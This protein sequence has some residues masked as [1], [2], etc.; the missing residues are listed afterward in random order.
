MRKRF[1]W[2]S[3][4]QDTDFVNCTFGDEGSCQ[5]PKHRP[6]RSDSVE[7]EPEDEGF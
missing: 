2:F 3:R 1:Y 6:H 4:C 7:L 5:N